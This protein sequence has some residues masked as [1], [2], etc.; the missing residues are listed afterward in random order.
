MTSATLEQRLA[1]LEG[2]GLDWLMPG[3]DLAARALRE[4]DRRRR[5]AQA[6]SVLAVAVAVGA[7]T[8]GVSWAST[9]QSSS[10]LQPSARWVYTRQA[11][12]VVKPNYTLG[13]ANDSRITLD[14]NGTYIW[15]TQILP[16]AAGLPGN[17]TASFGVSPPS[18]AQI[19]VLA[20][21]DEYTTSGTYLQFTFT[22]THL[23]RTAVLHISAAAAPI[24]SPEPTPS[25][26]PLR[27]YSP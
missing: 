16:V 26:T 11:K 20:G 25:L 3:P 9:S 17:T 2:D 27:S 1:T 21:Q 15:D 8:L 14:H 19:G 18:A 22:V 5:T 12:F 23:H 10:T 7:V 24:A 4:H 13:Y 6:W